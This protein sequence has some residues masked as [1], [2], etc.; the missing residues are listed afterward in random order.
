MWGLH[1]IAII[2]SSFEH[3]EKVHCPVL[4]GYVGHLT[5][6]ANVPLE[7]RWLPVQDHQGISLSHTG[8][9]CSAGIPRSR[10]CKIS[11]SMLVCLLVF[12]QLYCW[13]II[14]RC[15]S[16]TRH[17]LIAYFFFLWLLQELCLL[18]WDIPWTFG[19]R[20]VLICQLGLAT[21]SYF[22]LYILNSCG[23]L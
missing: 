3:M 20:T 1:Q 14:H 11:H 8:R 5:I 23:F 22:V 6:P 15:S 9:W 4:F 18:F 2:F 16:S 21:Y 12:V 13:G 10:T 17:N 19:G 7:N